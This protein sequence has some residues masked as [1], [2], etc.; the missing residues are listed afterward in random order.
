MNDS[1]ISTIRATLRGVVL[2]AVGV[3]ALVGLWSLVGSGR[4]PTAGSAAALPMAAGAAPAGAGS[5]GS[6]SAGAAAVPMAAIAE[7]M[8]TTAPVVQ[9]MADTKSMDAATVVTVP[10]EEL[11][12]EAYIDEQDRRDAAGLID[13]DALYPE[14]SDDEYAQLPIWL[15]DFEMDVAD[16]ALDASFEDFDVAI[17][18]Q[19]LPLERLVEV[20]SRC[21]ERGEIE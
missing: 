14:Y 20:V 15:D 10:G 1:G 2:G 3:L 16:P 4:T 19:D 7:E 11:D 21:W 12:C 6:G 9:P 18:P 13:W 17:A 8:D 5:S